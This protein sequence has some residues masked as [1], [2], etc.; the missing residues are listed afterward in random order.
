MAAQISTL[1]ESFRAPGAFEWSLASMLSE[2]IPEVAAL[3]EDTV[4]AL[5]LAF[6]EQLDTLG[7]FILHLN[8]FVPVV[9]NTGKSFRV[10]LL[11]LP[12]F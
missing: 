9:R 4:T 7:Q 1:C 12:I 3:L 2:V 5:V 10:A 11:F 8:S 6:E